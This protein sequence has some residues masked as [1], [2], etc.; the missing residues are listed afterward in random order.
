MGRIETQRRTKDMFTGEQDLEPLYTFKDFPI[1]CGVTEEG[2]GTDLFADMEW[3]ISRGSGMVQ[4][5]GLVPA[6][7]L[8]SKSHNAGIGGI[9]KAHHEEFADFLHGYR[10]GKVV[11]IGGGNGIL[12]SIYNGKYAAGDWVII[13]PTS[14]EI[15]AG[16]RARYVQEMWADGLD[17]EGLGGECGTLVHSHLMEHQ[18]DLGS[19][20]GLNA[21]KLKS[22]QH[23]VFTVPDLKEWVRRKYS[24]ALFFEHTY[25]IT[26]DYID[27]ILGRYGFK[28]LRK[29]YFGDG[30]SIF[31]ATEKT[32]GKLSG[33]QADYRELYGLNRQAF[34]DY[35]DYNREMAE[36][37]NQ[38][39]E[40]S[41]RDVWLFGA[42]IFSQY[43]VNNGLR[44]GR[45]KGI[46]DNDRL[47]QGKRLYGTKLKVFPPKVLREEKEPL[48]ILNAG[49]YTKEIKEDI[50]QNINK[51]TIILE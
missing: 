8:Y 1:Y 14:V 9:W 11:E 42:H 20:M 41:G 38:F 5:G 32:D 10:A 40:E 21:S 22:G 36:K 34:V 39:I 33:I 18:Y 2:P 16:C 7:L 26:E 17:L 12:N 29:E 49:A 15:A 13:D 24:N 50:L 35:I 23:M 4:L 19:F 28:I 25:L 48:L 37:A 44:V 31:Y 46:L 30:H 45:I 6:E 47:K 43:L 51:N 3:M 27:I